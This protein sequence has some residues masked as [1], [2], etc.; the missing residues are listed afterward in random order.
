M[1]FDDAKVFVER[2]A[3]DS[4]FMK[5]SQQL[6]TWLEKGNV[7]KRTAN[8]FY[9]L[10][11]SS[12]THV[13]RLITEKQTHEDEVNK[14]KLLFKQRMQGI[15]VQRECPALFVFVLFVCVS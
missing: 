6:L 13:R 8:L 11:Q 7:D 15:L 14:A 10:I 3:G 1:F 12:N 2:C 4:G 5:G 9:S